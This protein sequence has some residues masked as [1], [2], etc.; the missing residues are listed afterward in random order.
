MKLLISTALGLQLR[1]G[2]RTMGRAVARA[3]TMGRARAETMG[4]TRTMGRAVARAETMGRARAETMGRA[5][6]MGRAMQ[7]TNVRISSIVQYMY[8]YIFCLSLSHL[9]S[10]L[11]QCLAFVTSISR[12]GAG[13]LF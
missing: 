10:P 9:C 8:M 3:E 5:R 12:C 11:N 7:S 6:T 1:A 2:T 4:R 13:C